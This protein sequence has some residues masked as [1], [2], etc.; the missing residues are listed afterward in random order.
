MNKF[1]KAITVT[2][3]ATPSPNHRRLTLLLVLLMVQVL[4]NVAWAQN[5][6]L[7]ASWPAFDYDGKPAQTDS[8]WVKTTVAGSR[9]PLRGSMDTVPVQPCHC[10]TVDRWLVN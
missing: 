5:C 7:N 4:P 3:C 9:L 2:E 8:S 6:R 1:M 10:L